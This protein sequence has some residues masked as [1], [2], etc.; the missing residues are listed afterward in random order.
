MKEKANG[1]KNEGN[2]LMKQE[3]YKEALEAYNKAID[4]DKSNAVYYCNRFVIK[5]SLPQLNFVL[6]FVNL[7]AAAHSKLADFLNSIEDCKNAL[8]ID[9]TYSKAWGRLGY[10][11]SS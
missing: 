8:K 1:H 9:P 6:N 3:K 5:T 4:I 2:E 10:F 11:I 7:R